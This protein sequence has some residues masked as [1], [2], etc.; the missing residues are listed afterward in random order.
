MSISPQ[1]I[2]DSL[3]LSEQKFLNS[4]REEV[5]IVIEIVAVLLAELGNQ[6]KDLRRS[7]VARR[8]DKQ[9]VDKL[10]S[11][12]LTLSRRL[13]KISQEEKQT[14]STDWQSLVNEANRSTKKGL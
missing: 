2:A 9:R 6:C 12:L 3:I 13:L 11:L 8:Q 14:N 1:G 5:E 4:D 10:V 7:D